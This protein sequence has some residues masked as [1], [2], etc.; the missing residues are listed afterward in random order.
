MCYIYKKIHIYILSS[1]KVKRDV[2]TVLCDFLC[3]KKYDS[4]YILATYSERLN[5]SLRKWML[6]R[7]HVGM[8]MKF[9][10]VSTY[11]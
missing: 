5:R 7:E 8:V 2:K 3:T 10:S 6:E 4:K 11:I 1:G 9:M